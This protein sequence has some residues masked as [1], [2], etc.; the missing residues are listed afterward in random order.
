MGSLSCILMM[1]RSSQQRCIVSNCVVYASKNPECITVFGVLAFL[2][3]FSNQNFRYLNLKNPKD[4]HSFQ[5]KKYF[6][7]NVDF[8]LI[9]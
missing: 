3:L 6:V 7:Y 1:Q 8:D 9:L 2:L 4:I 5:N